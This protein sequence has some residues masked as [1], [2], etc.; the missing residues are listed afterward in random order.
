MAMSNLPIDP[1]MPV[2]P[3]VPI[4][5]VIRVRPVVRVA[6]AFEKSRDFC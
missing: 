5:A 1:T 4:G 6:L 3:G 2:I